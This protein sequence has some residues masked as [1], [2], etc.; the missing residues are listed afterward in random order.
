MGDIL[1]E[2]GRWER[3]PALRSQDGFLAGVPLRW[4]A[5]AR[6]LHLVFQG[7][8]LQHGLTRLGGDAVLDA[9]AASQHANLLGFA[10]DVKV[11]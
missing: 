9:E 2:A 4:R 1:D 5:R 7:F 10:G 11:L 3:S 6:R 8:P